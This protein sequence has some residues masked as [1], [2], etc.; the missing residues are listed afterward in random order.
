MLRISEITNG[1]IALPD[2]VKSNMNLSDGDGRRFD[3]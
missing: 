3:L 1:T 2:E